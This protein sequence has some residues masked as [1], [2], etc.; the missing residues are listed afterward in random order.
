MRRHAETIKLFEGGFSFQSQGPDDVRPRADARGRAQPSRPADGAASIDEMPLDTFYGPAICLDVSP[1]RAAGLRHRRRPRV[2]PRAHRAPARTPATRC[3]S[4]PAPSTATAARPSTRSRYTGLDDEAPPP[5][6]TTSGVKVFG[7]DS[8]SPD[9]P[10]SRTYPVHMMCREQR[11]HALREPRQPRRG[12]RAA[13]F[14]F[15]GF[16]LRIRAG[17]GAPGPRR[18]DRGGLNACAI[19]A[20][21]RSSSPAP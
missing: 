21:T 1:R 7:V 10:I 17:T 5:G 20:P 19:R 12:D 2:G 4:A 8:P 11:H 6:C 13:R 18:R 16:P 14:T 3:C 15:A 9:N